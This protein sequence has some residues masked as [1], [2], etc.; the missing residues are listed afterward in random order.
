MM[1]FNSPQTAANPQRIL[2][3]GA[4]G[5]VGQELQPLLANLGEVKALGRGQLDLTQPDQIQAQVVAYQPTI[6]VNAAAYTAVD[7]AEQELELAYAING[8]APTQ[9]AQL[10]EQMGV[11]LLHISTDYVFDGR[12]GSP[13]QPEDPTQ[14]LGVYGASKLAG[15]VGIRQHS[16]RHWIVRTAWVHG[17]KG[18]VNFVK[19]ML[20]LGA[21]RPEVRVVADQVGSPTWAGDLAQALTQLLKLHLHLPTHTPPNFGTYHFTNSGVASWYDVALAIFAEARAIGFPLKIERVV[22]ITTADYPTPAQRP[23]YSVLAG[24]RLAT[25]LGHPAPHWQQGLRQMLI[26]LA[27]QSDM[28]TLKKP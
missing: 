9:L 7:K 21:E 27:E 15:E 17:A 6:I 22:P 1:T 12:K 26:E 28:S 19:T 10:A 11:S 24:E 13:Y 4:Q 16:Q 18:Q 20:R 3:L 23:A 2:L 25:L 8:A 5:Q 14:P